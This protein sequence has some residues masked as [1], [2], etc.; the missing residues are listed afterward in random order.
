MTETTYRLDSDG[1]HRRSAAVQ[2][3]G[4]DYDED[5]F[6]TLSAMQ[7][8]HFW[9]RGRH[10]FLLAA[11]DRHRPT[12]VAPWAAID[13][14]GGVGGWVR[15]L[16]DRRAAWFQPVALADSSPVALR[17]AGAVLPE[18]AQRFQIDLMDLGWVDQWDCVFLLDVIE[19]LQ[20]DVR[21]LREARQA[22]KPGGVIFVTVPAL[23]QF[24]SYNDELSHHLRRYVRSD[25]KRLAREAG[26]V[27][28]DARYFMFYLSPLYWLARRRPGIARMSEA[29]QRELM[30]RSHRVPAPALNA[31]LTAVMG[32]ETPLGHWLS[33]PWGTSL[34]GV[35]R[36][37]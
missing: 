12:A 20:D 9:Y 19:H 4:E 7:E 18:S 33:F 8:R 15:Y 22:L 31:V 21:A 34:L 37:P 27:L 26:L 23:P 36:K 30:L 29:E 5:G 14:G 1:I 6:Q 11:L 32:A 24:W 35:F 25:F 28:C 16:V 10:R 17:M 2:H 3:R 13:L